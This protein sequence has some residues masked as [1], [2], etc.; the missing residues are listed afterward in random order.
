[1]LPFY[2]VVN[3]LFSIVV[4]A[5]TEQEATAQALETAKLSCGKVHVVQLNSIVECLGKYRHKNMLIPAA[6]TYN[7]YPLR[8]TL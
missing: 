8:H 5:D 2:V 6:R 1:M 4:W 7:E 3:D